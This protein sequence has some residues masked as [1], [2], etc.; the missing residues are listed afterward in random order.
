[1]ID[2]DDKATGAK[3]ATSA[4][5]G[6]TRVIVI[7]IGK[8]QKK[9]AIKRLRQGRGKLMPKIEAAVQDIQQETGATNTLPIVFVVEKKKKSLRLFW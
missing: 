3:A 8:K 6:Y 2:K 1:M 7:D 9:K 5:A 4:K